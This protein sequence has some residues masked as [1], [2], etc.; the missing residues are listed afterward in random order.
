MPL[1]DYIKLLQSDTANTTDAVTT[2][3]MN[4]GNANPGVNKHGQWGMHVIVTTAFGNLTEGANFSIIHSAADDLSTASE[5]HTSMFIPVDELVAGAHFFLPACSRVLL[6]YA[7]GMFDAV[8]TAAN[9]GKT[10]IYFGPA[11]GV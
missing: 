6:Q 1:Y 3:K 10:T 8:S 2:D 11:S 9:A 4:F 5:V 7:C